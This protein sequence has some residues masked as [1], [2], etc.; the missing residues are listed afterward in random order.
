VEITSGQKNL[1]K[2]RCK[3]D[4]TEKHM[5]ICKELNELYQR[6]NKDYGDSFSESYKEH[7]LTMVI[8][9]LEDK[10][11]RLK[12]LAKNKAEV[13]DES[14]RDTIIDLSNYGILGVMELDSDNDK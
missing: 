14:V 6:K 3:M 1:F 12:N 7:G 4:K 10:L 9:R 5:G 2:M 8:I 13:K 11:R